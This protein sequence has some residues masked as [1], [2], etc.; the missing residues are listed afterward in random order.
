MINE[1]ATGS[2]AHHDVA[3]AQN[4]ASSHTVVSGDRRNT[5]TTSGDTRGRNER[6][7]IVHVLSV[8][9]QSLKTT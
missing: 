6:V 5:I 1:N 9:E 2:I 8:T 4:V 3:G 7:S